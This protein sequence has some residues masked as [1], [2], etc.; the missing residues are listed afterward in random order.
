MTPE[1]EGKIGRIPTAAVET[2][3]VRA[4][5]KSWEEM[6][7]S[8]RAACEAIWRK[9]ITPTPAE[10]RFLQQL[11]GH[12]DLD[13]VD[14]DGE[15]PEQAARKLLD[16]IRHRRGR[17]LYDAEVDRLAKK[18]PEFRAAVLA[19]VQNAPGLPRRE[20]K[21]QRAYERAVRRGRAR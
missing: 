11:P 1:E 17:K 10:E 19:M 5:F 16:I 21:A 13:Q 15:T 18:S 6:R 8:T 20:P 3:A 14:Q 12:V 4:S 9:P 7:E 2:P